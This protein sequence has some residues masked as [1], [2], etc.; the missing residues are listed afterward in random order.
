VN[1]VALRSLTGVHRSGSDYVITPD[2]SA[3]AFDDFAAGKE[4]MQR[5][6]EA[7][8][9]ALPDIKARLSKVYASIDS[10]SS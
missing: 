4:L 7:A 6:R 5:G 9:A 1:D 2:T 3:H 8:E 10:P